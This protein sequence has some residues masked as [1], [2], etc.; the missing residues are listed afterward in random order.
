M[1]VTV[2]RA[3]TSELTPAEVDALHG[4]MTAAFDA[5]GGRFAETDWEHATGG[6]HVVVDDQGEIVSH[7]SVVDRTLEIGGDAVRAGYVEAVGTWPR[8]QRRGYATLIMREIG[9]VIRDRYELGALST[10]VPAF[11]ERLGWERWLGP[12]FVRMATGTERTLDDDGGIM[13]LRTPK[14]SPALDLSAPIVCDWR[15]GDV[16]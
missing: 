15:E 7:G 9:D 11:Y 16:W 4:M 1:T 13:V 6:V 12:T 8:H 5:D 3:A 14:T 2:R 10:P